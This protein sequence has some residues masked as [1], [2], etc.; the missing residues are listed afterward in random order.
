MHTYFE[1]MNRN[2][3]SIALNLKAPEG[4]EVL[5]RLARDAD[6]VI[7][8]F[9]P[10]VVERLGADYR[11]LVEHNPRIITVTASGLGREGPD[12]AEGVI[13]LTGQARSGYLALTALE[14]GSPRYVGSHALADQVGAMML[15]YA[16]VLAVLARERYGVG[17]D[18]EVSQLGSMLSLQ[19]LALNNYLLMGALPPIPLRD[20]PPNPIF[21]VYR[22]RDGKWLSLACF[23]FARYWPAT[24]EALG[25]RDCAQLPAPDDSAEGRAQSRRLT[26]RLAATFAQGDRDDWLRKLRQRG[27]VCAPVQSYPEIAQDPQVLANELIAELSHPQFGRVREVGIAVKLSRTPGAV[28]SMA[29][30]HGQHTEE[31]LLASGYTWSD[32]AELRSRGV[33]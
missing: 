12:A 23:Q 8:N 32:I 31:V 17:Q 9:R 26:E 21:N 15:A 30:E 18:V 2:K 25:L 29:P 14:D 13:D 10:G 5:H 11:S 4:R 7:S 20:Q 22:A 27:I 28:R 6:V 1:T 19:A 16:A 24:C 3:R 33:I